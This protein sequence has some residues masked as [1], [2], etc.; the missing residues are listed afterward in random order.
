MRLALA[1]AERGRE[2]VVVNADASQL[3]ADLRVL[4]ARPT[5]AEM[6]GVE[7]RLFG[8]WDG[9]APCSAAD[10]AQAARRE[11]AAIHAAQATPILV[12]GTGLYLRTLLEGI[13]PGPPIDP[14]IRKAVRTLATREAYAALRA[15]DPARAAVLAPGDTARIAR[16]L[17]VVRSTGKPLA[18]WQERR[19]GGIGEQVVLHPAI[20]LPEREALYRRCD[21]RFARMLDEGGVEEVEALLAR[22]LDPALPAMRAIGVAEIAGWLA[23]QWSR[24]EALARGQQ[25]TRNYA[26]RQYTWFHRQPPRDWPR[27]ESHDFAIERYFARLLL[28]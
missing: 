23:G 2:G 26:K 25:A 13:A 3:Y 15:E 19:E 22:G 28:N 8:A 4:S 21:A 14:A 1:L 10:W 11:I 27:L 17:E 12:G 20:V 16:A 24:A 5:E 6:R 9:A 7:H 18:H